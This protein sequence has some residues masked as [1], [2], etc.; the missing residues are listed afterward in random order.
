MSKTSAMASSEGSLM[1]D[2]I[3]RTYVEPEVNRRVDIGSFESGT[4]VHRTQVIFRSEKEPTVRLNGEVPGDLVVQEQLEVKPA[5]DLENIDERVGTRLRG[6]VG[7]RLA[8]E[9]VGAGHVTTFKAATNLHLIIEG[10]QDNRAITSQLTAADEFIEVS[11]SALD[12]VALR[13]FAEN[14]FAA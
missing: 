13:A 5:Q 10:V 4:T 12:A 11:E 7:D 3:R 8:E 2:W 1:W 14:A 9:D 6:I